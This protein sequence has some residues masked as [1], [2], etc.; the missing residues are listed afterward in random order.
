[1]VQL[2]YHSHVEEFLIGVLEYVLE[3]TYTMC[4]NCLSQKCVGT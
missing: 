2:L 3:S 4:E 1:M